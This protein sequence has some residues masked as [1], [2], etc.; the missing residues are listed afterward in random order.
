MVMQ[1]NSTTAAE[2]VVPHSTEE[3]SAAATVDG[4]GAETPTT[5]TE[6]TAE[7]VVTT[8]LDTGRAVL[9]PMSDGLVDLSLGLDEA[10]LGAVH[11]GGSRTAATKNFVSETDPCGDS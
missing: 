7:K 11:S 8:T 4:S 10:L 9:D 5:A 2:Q 6:E 3:I 1:V